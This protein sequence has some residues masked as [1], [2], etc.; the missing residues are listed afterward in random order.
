MAG[1]WAPEHATCGVDERWACSG[2]A[3]ARGWWM[4]GQVIHLSNAAWKRAQRACPCRMSMPWSVPCP[5]S[6]SACPCCVSMPHVRAVWDSVHT[7]PCAWPSC[8]AAKPRVRAVL[9][10]PKLQAACWAEVC[11]HRAGAW[12]NGCKGCPAPRFPCATCIVCVGVAG[13]RHS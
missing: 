5:A 3:G 8:C 7:V 2:H 6:Q 11:I 13:T 4:V 10:S 9:S 12:A 1:C